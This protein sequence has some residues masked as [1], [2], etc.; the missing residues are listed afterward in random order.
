MYDNRGFN[1]FILN[2]EQ[3]EKHLDKLN[4]KHAV[5]NGDLYVGVD[6][7]RCVRFIDA[8]PGFNDTC[9]VWT[10][11]SLETIVAWGFVD[12]HAAKEFI[13]GGRYLTDLSVKEL[14]D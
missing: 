3:V 5:I 13:K 1:V 2:K 6:S 14:L 8:T 10:H 9:V 12:P 4:V 11:V 7:E